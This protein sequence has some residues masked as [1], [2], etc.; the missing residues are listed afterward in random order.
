MQSR[1][2]HLNI[3]EPLTDNTIKIGERKQITERSYFS[4]NPQKKLEMTISGLK[5]SEKEENEVF[6]STKTTKLVA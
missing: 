5:K 4:S 2:I 6:Q 1:K 3:P